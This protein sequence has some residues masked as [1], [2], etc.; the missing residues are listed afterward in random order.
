MPIDVMQSTLANFILNLMVL[1]RIGL[2]LKRHLSIG[3]SLEQ[4]PLVSMKPTRWM[5]VFWKKH[6]K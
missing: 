5:L 2:R 1:R 4:T 6:W 3:I